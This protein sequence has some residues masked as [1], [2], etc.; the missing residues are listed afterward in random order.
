MPVGVLGSRP[1]AQQMQPHLQKPQKLPS[2]SDQHISREHLHQKKEFGHTNDVD[3]GLGS[4]RVGHHVR[5]HICSR[6]CGLAA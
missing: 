6:I 5:M 3:S 2:Q 4:A 1:Q